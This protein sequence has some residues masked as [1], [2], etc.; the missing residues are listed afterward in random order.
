MGKYVVVR[1]EGG[2]LFN[3]PTYFL[4]QILYVLIR[5]NEA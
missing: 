3:R 2:L 4:E 1:G 5:K